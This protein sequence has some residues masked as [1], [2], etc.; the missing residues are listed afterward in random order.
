MTHIPQPFDLYPAPPLLKHHCL[1]MGSHEPLVLCCL[2]RLC[3]ASQTGPSSLAAFFSLAFWEAP[4]PSFDSHPLLISECLPGHS[5]L[6]GTL[7]APLTSVPLLYS[8]PQPSTC[9]VPQ[10]RLVFH[11]LIV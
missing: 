4:L 6:I 3:L 8:Q 7:T 1:H 10:E 2:P 11:V 9:Q 5:A